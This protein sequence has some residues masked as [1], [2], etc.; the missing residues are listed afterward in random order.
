MPEITFESLDKVPEGLRDIAK[1]A[2]GGGVV[3]NVVAKSKLDEFRENNIALS[4]ERDQLKSTVSSLSAIV[5]ENPEEFTTELETLRQ[6]AQQVA[7]GKLKGSDA[8]ER[9]V[10]TRVASMK[11]DFERR[12]RDTANET[13]AWK[14]KA[15]ENDLKFKNSL[16]ER[17][18]T[19]AVVNP[20]S[21]AEARALPDLIARATKIFVVDDSGSVIPKDGEA[22]IYGS[23]GATPMTMGEWLE[24]LKETAPHFFKS[25]T[26]GGA[27]GSEKT[28]LPGNYTQEEWNKLSSK[29]KLELANK[30]KAA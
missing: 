28:G 22:T 11:E 18:V 23:D 15:T 13:K 27:G 30:A 26:G 19:D 25:S 16:I 5:G 2:E 4:T 1:E 29:K 17:A 3:I 24:G 6:T 9:E 20:E 21:G 14:D 7:D 10:S 8:V 12:L